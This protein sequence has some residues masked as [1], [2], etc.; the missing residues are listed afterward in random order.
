MFFCWRIVDI[1]EGLGLFGRDV[2]SLPVAARFRIHCAGLIGLISVLAGCSSGPNLPSYGIVPDFSLIDQT[3]K[4]FS[5]KELEGQV[6][7][8]NFI[9]TTC[10]G[11]CPRMSAQFRQIQKN[12]GEP[13]GLRFVSFTIDPTRDTPE[14]LAEYAKRFGAD[15][16]RWAFL[17]GPQPELNKLSTGPFHAGE[18]DGSLTHSTRFSLVDRKGRIRGYYDSSDPEKIQEL[19]RDIGALVK[20]RA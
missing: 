13:E 7:V 18:I 15:A 9:F 8:A 17:T 10:Q 2:R 1:F 19:V 20:V 5:S 4:T 16:G 3:G 6:W 14:V 11:P 12:T